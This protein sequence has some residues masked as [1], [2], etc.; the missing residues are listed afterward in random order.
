MAPGADDDLVRWGRVAL[1]ETRGRRS[2]RPRPAQVG[3]IEQ[4]DGSLLVAANDPDADW[5]LNLLAEPSCRVT[6]G[7]R[8]LDCWAQVLADAEHDQAVSA[9]ILRYGTPSERLGGGP[10]FRLLPR[11]GSEAGFSGPPTPP[12]PST[13]SSTSTG[14]PS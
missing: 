1:L 6:V 9:L 11:P 13:S 7:D 5:A 2:G 8:T 14:R 10:A 12:G 3:F 4:A